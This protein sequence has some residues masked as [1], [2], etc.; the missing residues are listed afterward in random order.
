MERIIKEIKLS[1]GLLIHDNKVLL[2]KDIRPGQ[3]HFF[4][5]GGNVEAGESV[6]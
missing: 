5:P 6:K 4:L 2:V 3:G 1:R